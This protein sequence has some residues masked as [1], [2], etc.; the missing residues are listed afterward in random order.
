M[1]PEID[2]VVALMIK[3]ASKMSRVPDRILNG[4]TDSQGV[5]ALNRLV[6]IDIKF[7]RRQP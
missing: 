6:Q 4:G 7:N 2:S 3:S 1:S 5:A